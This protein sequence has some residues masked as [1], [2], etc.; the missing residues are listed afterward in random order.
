MPKKPP[1]KR[2]YSLLFDLFKIPEHIKLT[3]N[4]RRDINSYL[5][6]ELRGARQGMR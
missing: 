4:D 6:S 5:K 2:L 1:D 3:S